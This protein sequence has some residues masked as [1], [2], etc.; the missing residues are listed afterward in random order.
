MVLSRRFLCVAA[1]GAVFALGL[2]GTALAADR[3]WIGGASGTWSDTTNWSDSTAPGAGEAAIFNKDVVID[4]IGNADTTVGELK[5]KGDATL[6]LKDAAHAMTVK[7]IT[8]EAGKKAVVN[9]EG[10]DDKFVVAD[11]NSIFNVGDDAVLTL[12]GKKITGAGE[13][14]L[15]GKGTLVLEAPVTVATDLKITEGGTL[16]V[17]VANA[18]PAV[19]APVTITKG[20]LTL[21]RGLADTVNKIT[22]TEGVLTLA[23]GVKIGKDAPL[24]G[25][26]DLK[27]AGQ[28]VLSGDLALKELKTVEGSKITANGNVLTIIP[29]SPFVLDAEIDKGTLS[30]DVLPG[31]TATLSK[32]VANV[33]FNGKSGGAPTLKIEERVFVNH[34]DIRGS[35]TEPARL[36]FGGEN[37]IGT[38]K[39]VRTTPLV[40]SYGN[41][42]V[43]VEKLILAG[44]AALDLELMGGTTLTIQD[45]T[46][47]A[48]W[49]VK[50]GDENTDFRVGS[51]E[52]LS[53]NVEVTLGGGTLY[54]PHGAYPN[55]TLKAVSPPVQPTLE[56][57]VFEG[58]PVLTVGKVE[59]SG[60]DMRVKA[61][62][63]A[64]KRTLEAGKTLTL[65]KVNTAVLNGN[66]IKGVDGSNN[67][68]DPKGY[69]EVAR[70]EG[71]KTEL[72]LTALKT[73]T[74]PELAAE[75]SYSGNKCTVTVKVSGDVK[76]KESDTDWKAEM[77][78]G[79]RPE[80]YPAYEKPKPGTHTERGAV[81]EV[82]LPSSFTTGTLRVKASN[83]EDP[84]FEGFVDVPLERTTPGGEG[85][86]NDEADKPVEIDNTSWTATALTGESGD[87]T[88][89]AKIKLV[90]TPKSLK[91]E[92]S[93]MKTPK[94]ELLDAAGKVV[95]TSSIPS[96]RASA[97]DYTL[98]LT[99]R[100]TK[101]EI[102]AGAEIK[103][104]TVTMANGTRYKI[105]VNKKLKDMKPDT[106][107][108][109]NNKPGG[110]NK[111]GDGNKPGD[112]NPGDNKPGDGNKPGE[113]RKGGSG[114]GCD[115]GVGGLA[116]ALGA[117]F[118][119]RRKV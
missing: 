23:Q 65:L 110:D 97:K 98:K 11:A 108:P 18:L 12:T 59:I 39:F 58:D 4:G 21:N 15:L 5:F 102:A 19:A 38:L 51:A 52:L 69:W 93:G 10:D 66:V 62:G 17:D 47:G 79:D 60:R 116:L 118:L 25:E 41:L 56:A 109:D 81:F 96:V 28:L 24:D 42:F 48:K 67:E 53:G 63:I 77:I 113:G 99:C 103:T 26:V 104:V 87:V 72:V 7:K 3:T 22:V 73:I 115:A 74:V 117:A 86:G 80:N 92:V 54:L 90:G 20:N 89:R 111:P 29:T 34:L 61:D 13:L 57:D 45:G 46:P 30:L 84:Y 9:S 32:D 55:L 70:L 1:L 35:T 105:A 14:Q 44:G 94:A 64:R 27:A 6:T 100:T 106:N 36:Q 49:N 95:L 37:I 43:K 31:Q 112:N 107:K 114:G 8:V 119:L 75:A 83:K 71:T 76:V 2:A 50:M 101:A 85:N 40:V 82:T 16:D 91:V 88:L 33:V 78:R 68:A